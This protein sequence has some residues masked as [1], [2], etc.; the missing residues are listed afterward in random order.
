MEVILLQDVEK[1]GREGEVVKIK[2]GY[3]RNYLIPR[4]LAILSSAQALKIL[5]VKKKRRIR[6]EEKSKSAAKSIS[7]KISS[8][9]CTISVESG[10]DDKIFGT[11]TPEMIRNALMQE[12]LNIDKKHILIEEPVKKL[13]VYQVKI[14]VH[15]EVIASLRIWVVK[16]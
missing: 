7:E 9:S 16:K 13:G 4:K 2:D 11:V 14:K 3:G 12:E 10:L 6:E 1:L 5:E 8:L 15:P